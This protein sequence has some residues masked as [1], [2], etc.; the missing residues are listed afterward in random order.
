MIYY[1]ASHEQ[2]LPSKL[3]ELVKK[4]EHAGFRGV[5]SSDHFHPWSSSQSQGGFAW[6]WLGAALQS[7]IMSF[8]IVTTPSY[9]YHPAILAQASATLSEMFPQRFWLCLGS[10]E[11]LNES[12]TGLN[13]PNKE[14]RNN[15]LKESAEIIQ[16]LWAGETVTHHGLITVEEAYLYTRPKES[17]LLMCAALTTE[18]AKW[19]GSWADGL[20]TVAS[21]LE[22]AK[23]IINAFK[24]G[25]GNKKPIFLK[26][27][28]SYAPNEGEALNSAWQQW[29]YTVLGSGANSMLRAP[30]MFDE[31]SQYVRPEDMR[32]QVF[33]SSNAEEHVEWLKQLLD[34]GAERISV[35]NVNKE[36][37]RF[38][39]FYKDRVL[40]EF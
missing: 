21:S 6:S 17:P 33:I 30:K 12:I 5:L 31:A 29:K 14:E 22:Q 3:L 32:K 18:T 10:G 7:T 4:A 28:T 39:S 2:F 25:G 23:K 27:Q 36:Q 38:I 9:R 35:H 40:T 1:H 24:E 37:E 20:V 34:T 15:R 13:W 11:S 26:A 8:G 19:L 16:R